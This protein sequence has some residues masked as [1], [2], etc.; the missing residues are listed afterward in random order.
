MEGARAGR[1]CRK[2]QSL[3]GSSWKA[4]DFQRGKA[5][6]KDFT[7]CVNELS[8]QNLLASSVSGSGGTG[9]SEMAKDHLRGSQ[10]LVYKE[11]FLTWHF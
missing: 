11:Y 6:G 8:L 4:T 3:L 1:R 10:K 9:S 7:S 5:S 2:N